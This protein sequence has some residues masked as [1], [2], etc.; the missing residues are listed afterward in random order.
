MRFLVCWGCRE[1]PLFSTTPSLAPPLAAQ[2]LTSAG[3]PGEQVV[4]SEQRTL[5]ELLSQDFPLT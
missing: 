3:Q 2:A 4:A 1:E 5:E